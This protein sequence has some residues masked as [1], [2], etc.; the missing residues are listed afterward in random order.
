MIDQLDRSHKGGPSGTSTVTTT[1]SVIAIA[2][3][4]N[5]RRYLFLKADPNNTEVITLKLHAEDAAVHLQGITLYP[6]DFQEFTMSSMYYGPIR[7]IVNAGT[8][9]LQW[10]EGQ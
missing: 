1:G 6:G 4:G 5:R 10:H 9:Q 3:T 2:D 8:E 7:A